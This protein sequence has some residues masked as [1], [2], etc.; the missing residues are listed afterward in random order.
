MQQTVA[1]ILWE[2]LNA[3]NRSLDYQRSLDHVLH[4]SPL[5]GEIQNWACGMRSGLSYV[6][7][8]RGGHEKIAIDLGVL[9]GNEGA[10]PD[11]G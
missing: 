10:Q 6:V 9:V 7:Q 4:E 3:V 8:Y 11:G 5:V 2:T 1:Q